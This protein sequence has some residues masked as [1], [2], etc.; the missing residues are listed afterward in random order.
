MKEKNKL[1]FVLLVQQRNSMLSIE[2]WVLLELAQYSENFCLYYKHKPL[3]WDK[4]PFFL[5]MM[6]FE[7]KTNPSSGSV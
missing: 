3:S 4:I 7:D 2:N 5:M 6:M 1:T